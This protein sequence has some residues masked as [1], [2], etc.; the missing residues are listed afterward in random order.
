MDHTKN[1]KGGHNWTLD[2]G[3]AESVELHT[4]IQYI[5]RNH[6][7]PFTVRCTVNGT[8][9]RSKRGGGGGAARIV[10]E[11]MVVS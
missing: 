5:F 11:V 8:T 7:F 6:R 1:I 3:T 2:R 9:P 4:L 10:M